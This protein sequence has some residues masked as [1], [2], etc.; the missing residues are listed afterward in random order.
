MSNFKTDVVYKVTQEAKGKLLE[1]GN[2]YF[3]SVP[4]TFAQVLKASKKF[5]S[6]DTAYQLNLFINQD[7]MDKL[8]KIGLNKEMAQVGV[9]KIKKGTNRGETKYKLDDHNKPYEGMFAAQFSRNTVKRDANGVITK[10]YSPLK[11]VDAKGEPFTQEVGNGSICHVKMFAYRN[12]DG[13]LVVMMDTVVV[14]EHVP[15]SKAGDSFDEELGINIKN[16]ETPVSQ[17]TDEELSGT[18]TADSV[19]KV[20]VEG[21]DIPF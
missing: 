19:T 2:L 18:T 4:V 6:E 9:T 12:E 5:N 14:V 3:K 10:E 21:G 15:Y 7:T 16:T 1:C 20:S 8:D 13:M 11:V 17:D